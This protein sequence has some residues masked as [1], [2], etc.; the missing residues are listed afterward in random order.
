MIQVSYAIGVAEP[1]SIFVDTFGTGKAD[2]AAIAARLREVFDLTPRGIR[3]GLGLAAP[4][5]APTA[6]YGHFGRTAGEDGSFT[7]EKTDLAEKLK[8][9]A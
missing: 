9:L 4:I 2:E 7:W 5:Y 8:S 1:L 3:E 6:A